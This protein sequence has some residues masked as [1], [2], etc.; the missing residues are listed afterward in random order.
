MPCPMSDHLGKESVFAQL[1]DSH[2]ITDSADVRDKL[3]SDIDESEMAAHRALRVEDPFYEHREIF[4]KAQESMQQGESDLHLIMQDLKSFG[5]LCTDKEIGIPDR[6]YWAKRI[7]DL[8]ESQGKV[9]QAE[10]EESSPIPKEGSPKNKKRE[11]QPTAEKLHTDLLGEQ[12][13]VRALLQERWGKM[14]DEAQANWQLKRIAELRQELMQRLTEWLKYLQQLADALHDFAFEPGLLFDLS[15]GNLSLS[16]I[17]E[18]KKWAKY[19]SEDKEMRQLCDLLGR[20]RRADH[21]LRREWIEKVETFSEVRTDIHSREEFSGVRL[22]NSIEHA[23]PQEKALLAD[24]D[25]ALLFDIKFVEGRLMEF[26]TTGWVQYEAERM[27]QQEVEV[28]EEDKKGPL[29]VCVDTSGSM[30]GMPETIA[31]AVALY[32]ATAARQQ[33]RECFLINFSTSIETLD[34]SQPGGM[35]E[36][37]HFLQKSFRG[38]T[39]AAPALER[40]VQ[41]MQTKDYQKADLLV[42][43]DF[44]MGELPQALS[45]LIAAAKE[46][47]NRFFSLV[48]S[49]TIGNNALES[50]FDCEWHYQPGSGVRQLADIVAISARKPYADAV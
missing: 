48:I 13:T 34:L 38:G 50:V 17:A 44:V 2:K 24:A 29:I 37:I 20:M 14:L 22:G 30:Q 21:S 7:R 3:L 16:D 6:S 27:V 9:T 15:R 39:D 5:F 33:K 1:R 46:N 32:L 25:T 49:N 8:R 28:T 45:P 47:G 12:K 19:L 26:D 4:Q 10:Q 35:R 40:A 36:L 31:K 18:M 42:V 11:K 43:S 23:L 41:T